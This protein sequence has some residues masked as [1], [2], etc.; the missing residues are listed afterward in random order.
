VVPEY[1]GQ[2]NVTRT[3][4][5]ALN[6]TANDYN[7]GS[8]NA[9]TQDIGVTAIARNPS[10]N[11]KLTN[12]F[13][14]PRN[15]LTNIFFPSP[16]LQRL[17]DAAA[18]ARYNIPPTPTFNQRVRHTHTRDKQEISLAIVDRKMAIKSL[19]DDPTSEPSRRAQK[20]QRQW[21]R[22]DGQAAKQ[23]KL[24]QD[25]DTSIVPSPEPDPQ[26]AHSTPTYRQLRALECISRFVAFIKQHLKA[27]RAQELEYEDN[28]W[29]FPDRDVDYCGYT[30]DSP[31]YSE[32]ES[33]YDSPC[34]SEAESQ[35]DSDDETNS[36]N[37]CSFYD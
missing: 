20:R 25:L 8:S 36:Y 7:G 10:T 22:K 32:A 21:A 15:K 9:P 17:L 18:A 28:I 24:Q 6:S 37:T 33:Q 2:T 16:L 1:T 11:N 3:F 26:P 12:I 34:Y 30:Y 27:K 5:V 23:F 35:Y 29:A 31:C 4:P 13:K 19:S 14:P